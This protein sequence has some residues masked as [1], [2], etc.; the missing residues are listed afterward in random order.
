[1]SQSLAQ[2]YTH[3]VFSTKNRVP[4]INGEVHFALRDYLGGILRGLDCQPLLVGSV[5]DHVHILYSQSKNR[6]LVDVIEDVKTSSSK[7]VKT[8]SEAF[9]DFHWQRGYG[10]FSVSASCLEAV[11]RYIVGQEAHHKKVTFQDE[12]R[13]FLKQYSIEYDERYVWD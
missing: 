3:L 6:S 13:R 7:W 1:M 11:R 9:R 4:F 2:L 10:A 8:Q 12:F 5:S